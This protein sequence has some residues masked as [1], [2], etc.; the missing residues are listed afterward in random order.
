MNHRSIEILPNGGLLAE[1]QS[2]I[3]ESRAAFYTDT[4]HRRCKGVSSDFS[5]GREGQGVEGVLG[6]TKASFA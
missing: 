3:K 1:P 4:N 2:E 5:Q 6:R